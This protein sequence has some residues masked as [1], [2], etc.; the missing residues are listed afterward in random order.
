M[1]YSELYNE[2]IEWAKDKALEK[3]RLMEPSTLPEGVPPAGIDDMD[4]RFQILSDEIFEEA[5][6]DQYY[7]LSYNQLCNAFDRA[8]KGKAWHR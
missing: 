8:L 2:M 6:K 5:L 3:I 1:S 4:K 7:E